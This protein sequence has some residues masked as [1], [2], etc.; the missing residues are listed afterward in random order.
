VAD[1]RH[2]GVREEDALRAPPAP[3]LV[4]GASG[5]VGSHLVPALRARG[6]VVRAAARQ[7]KVLEARGWEG[8]ELCEADALEPATL[9]A[10]LAGVETAYYL[11]HSMA[12]G[13]RFVELDREA[14][15]NF[16]AAA[17]RRGVRRIVYL[18]GLVPAQAD[19]AHLTS[20]KET[21]DLLRRG[22]VPVIEVRAGIIVGPGSAAYE[23]MR[24]LV[25]HLPVMVTPRWVQ[26]KS[27]P[28]AIANLVEYLVRVAA[29]P[30]AQGRILDAGGP[31]YLSYEAM[32][33]EF[34][35]VV[36][37]SPRILRVP[38]L[39]P[40]LS[41]YWLGL[42]TTVPAR[43]GR[44]L[45]GGLKHD[46]PA[47]DEELRR[48]VP[49]R[50]LPF[51]EAVEAALEAERTHAVPAR[52]TEG[53]LM[54]RGQRHDH[55]FYAKKASGRAL[56][57]A[58]PEAVWNV[59]CTLGGDTGYFYFDVLWR[60]RAWLDWAA[61]GPGLSRGR[62]HP[63]EL[64]VGDVIDYWTVLALEP[65]R[66]LTLHFGMRAP[67]TGVLEFE[68][69]PKPEGT[70]VSVTAYWHPA[71][72]W[73]LVYWYAFVPFHLFLFSGMTRAIARRAE[74]AGRAVS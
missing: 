9:D 66:R 42:V 4:F 11:V 7:R 48:L 33:R 38:L 19:T 59:L 67:G 34:G 36:G 6:Y 51:R 37:R 70:L 61:G 50:L 45:V 53:A 44:A 39:T 12:A 21:G 23:V 58:T 73:G 20:R 10:A 2:G 30:Q 55:A 15:V 40:R 43:I 24:D 32:M 52:W 62:R 63:T 46:I 74:A 14:A 31:E 56:A 17:A 25:Y 60:I 64:R 68:L 27:S 26:S 8:V 28:I 29:L 71:G 18:G 1:P 72:L 16:A 49:Q 47:F 35:A 3:V 57:K 69:E 65:A 41:S 5:Y 13:R 22:P 54:F